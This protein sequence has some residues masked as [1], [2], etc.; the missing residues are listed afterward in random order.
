MALHPST[1]HTYS[2]HLNSYLTF[3][4][5]HNLPP[6]P[7]PDTLSFFIVYMLHHIQPRSVM[8]YLSGVVHQL[9]PHFP[10]VQ[11][12]RNSDLICHTLHGCAHC[13]SWPV[14]DLLWLTQLLCGFFGL[15][16]L[17]ELVWPDSP[18]LQLYSALSSCVDVSVNTL[19]F[20]FVVPRRKTDTAF[21]GN[22]VLIQHLEGDDDPFVLLSMYLTSHDL[23][24]PLHPFL[25]IKADSGIPTR[26]WFMHHFH[27]LFPSHSLGGHLLHA[28]GATS[29]ALS[30]IQ[31]AHIQAIG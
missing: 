14:D 13:L 4:A 6:E 30:G 25:W 24:F 7:T 22:H 12:A 26:S 8:A 29:L 17:G 5:L 15:L 20:S 19:S 9:L 2:S 11:A 23:C 27:Q 3:C 31:P 10:A 28:G 1:H 21:E 16:H 18:S